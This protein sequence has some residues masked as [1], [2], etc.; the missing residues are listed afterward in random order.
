MEAALLQVAAPLRP[1]AFRDWLRTLPDETLR[2]EFYAVA[3][4]LAPQTIPDDR[5]PEPLDLIGVI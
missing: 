3:G 5:I 1:G 4:P 2:S